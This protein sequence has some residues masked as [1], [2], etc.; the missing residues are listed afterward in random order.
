MYLYWEATSG[1]QIHLHKNTGIQGTAA[2]VKSNLVKKE[3]NG[4]SKIMTMKTRALFH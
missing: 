1:L 4:Y 2:V 3:S